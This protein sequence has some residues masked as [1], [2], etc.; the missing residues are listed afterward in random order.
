MIMLQGL[1]LKRAIVK[2]YTT[3]GEIPIDRFNLDLREAQYV[4]ALSIE[5]MDE[6]I[7][8]NPNECAPTFRRHYQVFKEAYLNKD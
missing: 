8:N 3:K 6:I 1:I 7:G 2:I 5:E 4:K